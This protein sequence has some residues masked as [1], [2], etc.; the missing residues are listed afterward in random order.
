MRFGLDM[1][2][3]S[4]SSLGKGVLAV[5]VIVG[6]LTLPAIGQSTDSEV[7]KMKFR[8]EALERE[9]TD[10][11]SSA[12]SITPMMTSD[13]ASGD[14]TL[15]TI[16]I[17]LDQLENE[18][19]TLTGQ[20]EEINYRIQQNTTEIAALGEDVDYR[21]RALEGGAPVQVQTAKPSLPSATVSQSTS[22]SSGPSIPYAL[23]ANEIDFRQEY[24]I[25][26]NYLKKG[27]FQKAQVAFQ[28]F[29]D[30]HSDTE[31]AS[32]AYYWLGE[33]YYVQQDYDNAVKYF[34]EGVKKYPNG[35]K[36]PD[37][38]LKLG[39]ALAVNGNK[40]SSC[41][42]FTKLLVDYPGAS[43]TIIQRTRTE[44]AKAGCV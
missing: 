28:A 30:D 35:T 31:L 24:E 40:P 44:K 38:M 8:L 6:S 36:A 1:S 14:P 7:A 43:Q 11:R 21:L 16:L 37:S 22:S 4:M 42:V 12:M 29:I 27:E 32:N 18:I 10:M 41:K 13:S 5:G 15:S 3:R 33:S 20:V 2:M 17:R 26:R 34:I 23:D 25:A 19:R 9:V 39:M